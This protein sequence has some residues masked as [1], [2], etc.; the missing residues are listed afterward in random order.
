MDG[1]LSTFFPFVVVF[2]GGR[3]L[4]VLEDLA[5]NG[6]RCDAL[7]SHFVDMLLHRGGNVPPVPFRLPGHSADLA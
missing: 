7:R 6:V 3:E 4:G 5:T 2:L 1:A